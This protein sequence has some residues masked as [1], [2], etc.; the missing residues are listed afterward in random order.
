MGQEISQ[1]AEI[2]N[3]LD[4]QERNQRALFAELTKI[5]VSPFV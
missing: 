1:I 4:V 5:L 3:T 2:N